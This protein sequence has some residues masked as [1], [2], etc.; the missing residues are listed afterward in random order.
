MALRKKQSPAQSGKD[1]HGPRQDAVLRGL[2]DYLNSAVHPNHVL[3]GLQEIGHRLAGNVLLRRQAKKSSGR[4]SAV[5]LHHFLDLVTES[6]WESKIKSHTQDQLELT[7]PVCPFGEH[8]AENSN[9]CT[10]HTAMVGEIAQ[11]QFGYAKVLAER[12]PGT[13][14]RNCSVRVHIVQ[15]KTSR[16]AVGIEYLPTRSHSTTVPRS[17]PENIANKLSARE[18]ETLRLVGLGFSDRQIAQDLGISVRTAENHVARLRGKLAVD[19]RGSL[20]RIA[21]RHGLTDP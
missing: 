17:L 9:Y 21:L 2:M 3:S 13:P 6:G 14:P 15:N 18:I 19:S 4:N 7:T 12:G 1:Q 20:I 8:A 11:R 10:L 5:A 16:A